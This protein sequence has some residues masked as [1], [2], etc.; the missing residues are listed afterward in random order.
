MA[1][2][3]DPG[4]S[5]GGAVGFVR[6]SGEAALAVARTW[7]RLLGDFAPIEMPAVRKL[8]TGVFEL[9][10]EF[11]KTQQG[12]AQVV[13]METRTAATSTGRPPE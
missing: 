13:V 11:L 9:T 4:G 7:A 1:N 10:G 3:P 8:V 5:D 12:I 2:L 6:T